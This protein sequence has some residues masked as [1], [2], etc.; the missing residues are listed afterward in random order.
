MED[1]I[2]E[3]EGEAKKLETTLSDPKFYAT[4][5]AEAAS[6]TA[7]LEA[8]KAEIARLYARWEEL[9]SPAK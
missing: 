8:V 1:A 7:E 2:F 5:A 4:R 9:E 6:V 3:K